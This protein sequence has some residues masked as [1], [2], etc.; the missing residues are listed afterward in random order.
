LTQLVQSFGPMKQCLQWLKIFLDHPAFQGF[1]TDNEIISILT[2]L[3]YGTYLISL[4]K[5]RPKIS[6]QL[7]WYST[8][9][10]VHTARLVLTQPNQQYGFVQHQKSLGS[11]LT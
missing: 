7:S 5:T 1:L 11:H 9:D 3:P 2:A 4:N 6:F 8:D 10:K